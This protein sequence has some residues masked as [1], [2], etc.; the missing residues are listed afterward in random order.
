MARQKISHSLQTRILRQVYVKKEKELQDS[1]DRRSSI[2]SNFRSVITT[3]WEPW[4]NWRQIA[5]CSHLEYKVHS[6]HNVV[7][8]MTVEQPETGV[9]RPES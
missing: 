5:L 7:Q 2:Q 1:V 4:W 6:Y 3:S 9:V 8:E